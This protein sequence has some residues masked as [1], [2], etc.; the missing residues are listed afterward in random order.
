MS[1]I[2]LLV[3]G[4]LVVWA[5]IVFNLLIRDRNRVSQSWSDVDVQLLRRHD[6]IPRLVEL[7]KGYSGYEKALH[8]S[9]A[10]LRNQ[11]GASPAA[12]GEAERAFGGDVDAVRPEPLDPPRD[13]PA[14]W[15]RQAN[16]GI[17][18]ARH[19]PKLPG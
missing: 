1:H 16:L 18:R 14:G 4:A 13:H 3:V 17:G 19:G 11:G 7:V 5:V 8:M 9:V 12:R 15:Q 6:L 10:E 2:A